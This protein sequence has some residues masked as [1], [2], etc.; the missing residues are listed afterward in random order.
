MANVPNGPVSG[1]PVVTPTPEPAGVVTPPAAVQPPVGQP[2]PGAV[3]PAVVQPAPA[4]AQPRQH[5]HDASGPRPVVR[6]FSHTNLY[7]WWPVWAVGY[8]MAF[9]TWMANEK[10]VIG[11]REVLMHHNKNL[12]VVFT[13]TLFLVILI[14]NISL[15]GTASVI[16]IL[17]AAFLILLLAY[18]QLWEDVLAFFGFVAVYMNLSFYLFL[19]TLIFLVW[20]FAVFI[21]DRLTYWKVVPGQISHETVVGAAERSYDTRGML[22]EKH[23]GDL[24]RHW[25]LGLGSG[26]LEITLTGAKSETVWVP[27]VLFIGTKVNK[28]QRLIAMKPT[29]LEGEKRE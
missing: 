9:L 23:R 14:T 3:A 17:A 2:A 26:D 27:N 21:Y 16:V 6:I 1:A 8:L 29:D 4:P 11:G 28:I 15:R 22:L 25:V 24:F 20:A 5:H 10:V 19:S 13:L 7:Y 12:G 18:L